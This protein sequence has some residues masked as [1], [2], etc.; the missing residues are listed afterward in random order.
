M[1]KSLDISAILALVAGSCVSQY[2]SYL[3]PERVW[4]VLRGVANSLC[5]NRTSV[6]VD[7]LLVCT[8]YPVG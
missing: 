2:T 4:F 3:F 5:R 7:A 6:Q 8:T 1:C